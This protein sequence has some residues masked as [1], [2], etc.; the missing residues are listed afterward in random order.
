MAVATADDVSFYRRPGQGQRLLGLSR[1]RSRRS[2][3]VRPAVGI[4]EI[5]GITTALRQG[6]RVRGDGAC[7]RRGLWRACRWPIS[8]PLRP[9]PVHLPAGRLQF[10][11]H[12]VTMINPNPGKDAGT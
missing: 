8:W 3:D 1:R 10:C 7:H 5:A 12:L 11:G 2:G 9:K 4:T 6:H